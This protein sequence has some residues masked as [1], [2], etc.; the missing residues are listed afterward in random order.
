MRN[1]LQCKGQLPWRLL[2]VRDLP[3]VWRGAPGA[4]I[5]R[6]TTN[7]DL[8]GRAKSPRG[9]NERTSGACSAST[10]SSGPNLAAVRSPGVTVEP[11]EG[12]PQW[13]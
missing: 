12:K 9:E 8:L 7:R 1:R 5:E 2:A 4:S 13:H 10:P 6:S 11:R 3:A